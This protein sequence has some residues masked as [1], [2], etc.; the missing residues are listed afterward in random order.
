MEPIES[1]AQHQTLV[2]GLRGPGAFPHPAGNQETIETHIS[3]VVLAGEFAYKIKKP[4]NLGFVDFSSLALRHHFCQEEIRLNRRSAPDLYLDVAPITGTLQHPRVNASSDAPILDYAVRMRRFPD[5]AR[6][7][8]V[9]RRGRLRPDHIDRLA[10]AISELH[11][12]CE[13]APLEHGYGAPE[14]IRCWAFENLAALGAATMREAIESLQAWTAHELQLHAADLAERQMDGHIRECH[15]DLHLGNL[16]LIGEAPLPFD[17]VEFNNRLRFIDVISDIAFTFMD[18]V[19]HD[20]TPLAW[21][22]IDVYL[23]HTGDYRGL[24]VLRFYAV[25]RAL[26]R[27]K[28]AQIRLHQPDTPDAEQHQDRAA[29]ARYIEV[30]GRLA[31]AGSPRLILTCGLAGSGKTTVAQVL[32]ERLGAIRVRSDVERRRLFGV[33]PADH[34]PDAVASGLYRADATRRTYERLAEV[35]GA[36]LQAGIPAIVD[37][38]FLERAQREALRDVA[39]QAAVPFSIVACEAS[40]ATLRDRITRRLRQRSDPSDATPQVLEHQVETFEPLTAQERAFTIRIDTDIDQE[41]L[42]R[43][44]AQ[45]AEALSAEALSPAHE[46]AFGRKS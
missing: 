45:A 17:C 9:A 31:T 41:G 34:R 30:A 39:A 10:L 14:E 22:L 37:A 36:I 3:T 26:V 42:E 4:V 27:A 5:E 29:A 1:L 24:A 15:G 21:R 44:A 23:Q 33:D 7:D 8:R 18:L 20:L 6:L 32:L 13:R 38:T 28:I 25:Y 16:V 11:A 2:A 35:A 12:H 46:P 43:R 19:E 40:L